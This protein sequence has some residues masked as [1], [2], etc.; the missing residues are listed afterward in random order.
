[1][2][3]F[4]MC[5]GYAVMIAGGVSVLAAI[6]VFALERMWRALTRRKTWK[7]VSAALN[8]WERNHPE[9]A[10]RQREREL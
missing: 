5:L 7:V 8:E 4:A 1:M 10:A 9:E 3:Q 2:N 6:W